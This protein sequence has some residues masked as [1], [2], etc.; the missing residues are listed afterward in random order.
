MPLFSKNNTGRNY[1]DN[2]NESYSFRHL[3]YIIK[4]NK[5]TARAP[6]MHSSGTTVVIWPYPNFDNPNYKKEKD[7]LPDRETMEDPRSYTWIFHAEGVTKFGRTPITLLFDDPD[8]GGFNKSE[9]NPVYMIRDTVFRLQRATDDVETPF[10]TSRSDNWFGLLKPDEA[11]GKYAAIA[12]PQRLY[13]AYVSVCASG[14]ES[15]IAQGCSY[16]EAP[17]DPAVILV[18]TRS[19]VIDSLLPA[20]EET[21]DRD[22]MPRYK[23]PEISGARFIHL[24]DR[25]LQKGTCPALIAHN[26][27]A[28]GA[29]GFRGAGV[30]TRRVLPAPQQASG[31]QLGG[32]GAFVSETFSGNPN[33][34]KINRQDYAALAC[35]KVVRWEDAIRGHT[36]DEAARVIGDRCGFPLSLLYHAW[37]SRPDWYTEEMKFRLKNPV[38]AEMRAPQPLPP[39]MPTRTTHA[40]G[41][42]Q[43]AISPTPAQ[44]PLGREAL[45]EADEDN[46]DGQDAWSKTF[47]AENG[48]TDASGDSFKL[49]QDEE[50]DAI[51]ARAQAE[52]QARLRK[53]MQ[54]Q[55]DP[56]TIDRSRAAQRPPQ[57]PGTGRK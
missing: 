6:E 52:A 23:H 11:S 7:V 43:P 5:V 2:Q 20:M 41:E 8:D 29:G 24:Y 26:Q 33:D 50:D 13:M 17:T 55:S 3:D 30:P 53:S 31:R 22:G 56:A 18:M 36:P 46:G 38:T 48:L 10:G 32:Y 37:K 9:H 21:Y 16:G 27:S 19:T 4:S 28:V 34:P 45:N 15:Y 51:D 47:G 39:Q 54:S 12:K 14:K 49:P 25:Q 57:P 44:R 1:L 42:Q 40:R 35:E